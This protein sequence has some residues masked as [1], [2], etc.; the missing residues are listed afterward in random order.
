MERLRNKEF[1]IDG[2]IEQTNEEMEVYRYAKAE[3]CKE[4]KRKGRGRRRYK[5]TNIRSGRKVN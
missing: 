5:R 2:S 4:K 1:L 3:I